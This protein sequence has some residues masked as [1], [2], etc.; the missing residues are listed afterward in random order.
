M[1]PQNPN[2][3][4][5]D[6]DFLSALGF[7]LSDEGYGEYDI[8]LRVLRDCHGDYDRAKQV[9]TKMMHDKFAR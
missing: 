7:S 3:V 9:L 4:K 5:L 6:E 1:M 2:A 8:C